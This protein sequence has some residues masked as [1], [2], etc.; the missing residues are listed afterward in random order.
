MPETTNLE[1]FKYLSFNRPIDRNH[2]V[3]M[4]SVLQNKNDWKNHPLLVTKDMEVID[5]QH[6][7]EASKLLGIP[8]HYE[9]SE[10]YRPEDVFNINTCQ[11]RWQPID[12]MHYHAELG[13]SEYT[14][15]R[16]FMRDMGYPLNVMLIWLSKEEDG[17]QTRFRDGKF[18]FRL[19]E[20]TLSAM[21]A[22]KQIID[23][24]KKK[25]IKPISIY[26]QQSF[27]KA[28]KYVLCNPM[29]DV[30]YLLS[31]I[32]NYSSF[33]KYCQSWQEYVDILADIHNMYQ[34]N[35]RIRVI[36]DGNKV[37]ISK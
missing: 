27:H 23:I 22:S 26:K 18:V 11:K 17:R 2:V 21:M 19:T 28:L 3:K 7:L 12:F 10:N 30:D 15:L 20:D 29:V 37:A 6:R 25:H 5:G 4:K 1:Q 33:I 36:K 14:K 9:I 31:K 8:V 34:K 35:N 32:E 24:L 13:N 16:S